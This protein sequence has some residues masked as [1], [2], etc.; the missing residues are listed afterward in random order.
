MSYLGYAS[1]HIAHNDQ[2]QI[3]QDHACGAGDLVFDHVRRR[4]YADGRH[5]SFISSRW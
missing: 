1:N 2:C 5:G 4:L 3:N